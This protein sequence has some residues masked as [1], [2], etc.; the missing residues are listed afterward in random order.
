MTYFAKIIKLDKFEYT[1]WAFQAWSSTKEQ[2][3][4]NYWVHRIV[5]ELSFLKEV[6]KFNQGKYDDLIEET[7]KKLHVQ[8]IENGAISKQ[9]CLNAEESLLVAKEDISKYEISFASHAHIDINW[10]WG[11][12][13][14][15]QITI[16]T[17]RTMLDIMKENENFIY[18]QSQ[19]VLYKIIEDYHPAMLEEIKARVAEKRWEITAS[20]WVEGDKNLANGESQARQ[21]LYTKNY[22]NEIFNVLPEDLIIDFEPDT[23]GHVE[24]I[25]EILDD[26]LVKFY[27]H[28]RG[29]NVTTAYRW[30][31]PSNKE[32]IV[33]RDPKVYTMAINGHIAKNVVE[34]ADKNRLFNILAVYG[35]SNHG[36][37]P[38]RK[39]I[40]MIEDMKH[41]PI[42]PKVKFSSY[43]EY[44][45]YL[46]EN[47][48]VLSVEKRE[49]NAVFNGCYT[50]QSRIKLANRFGENVLYDAET[51]NVI[52]TIN[53]G[54]P[55]SSKKYKDAWLNILTNQ[56]HDILP[57]SGIT[58]T[59][60]YAL[61]KFQE[62]M[63]LALTNK[64]LSLE[65]LSKDIDTSMYQNDLEDYYDTSYGAGVG[66][67]SETFKVSK[68]SRGRGTTRVYHV[69][70][71]LPYERTEQIQIYLWNYEDEISKIK[72]VNSNNEPLKFQK[73]VNPKIVIGGFDGVYETDIYWGHWYKTFTVE[74]NVPAFGYETIVLMQ[75]DELENSFPNYLVIEDDI[76]RVHPEKL[77]ILE[78]DL[79]KVTFDPITLRVSSYYDKELKQELT[80]L[81]GAGFNYILEDGTMGM[82]SWVVGRTISSKEIVSSDAT[83]YQGIVNDI[84]TYEAKV[85]ES[86]F[87]VLITLPKNSK[88]LNYV[89]NVAWNEIGEYHKTI[90]TLNYNF[91][92]KKEIKEYKYDIAFGVTSRVP[93]NIDVSGNS[94]ASAMFEEGAFIITTDSKYGFYGQTDS[95][96]V[97]LI[98][99]STD[100]DRYPEVGN[101]HF[102][103]QVGV[104]NDKANNS[105]IK[106]SKLL[107]HPLD[108]IMGEVHKGNEPLRNSFISVDKQNV[109][110]SSF[111]LSEDKT[112]DLIVRFYES[113]GVDTE[114]VVDINKEIKKANYSNLLEQSLA[115]IDVRNN[116]L[117]AKVKGNSMCSIRLEV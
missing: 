6:S 39:D 28:V 41:W 68:V 13:E 77:Y 38:T 76:P 89:V 46:E 94:F 96:G 53:N 111:K 33:Y 92:L 49:L 21:I 17:F 18:S 4:G 60:E 11:F 110:V 35:V 80:K 62:S 108:V 78:N 85:A 54:F 10:L 106:T 115:E 1:N 74:V 84:L 116:I 51:A 70:N 32:V 99:S 71:T 97:S 23:F 29:N 69:W 15:V 42:Y 55:Y 86:N 14:T 112:N 52:A 104:V 45:E 16:D 36:G 50:S 102:K 22:L 37:G 113:D 59:R 61:G 12:H 90:K 66:F 83:L 43:R 5:S 57:G 107:N 24:S 34:F 25:P 79:V 8:Y 44:Y 82:D 101:H 114:F 117:K 81:N 27:Y 105:L 3:K 103:F 58:Y 64:K 88:L 47:K 91:P 26:G 40:E 109:I 67:N 20:T 73:T 2:S 48:D 63:A 100:P 9:D 65:N 75:D 72:I 30:I 7:S 31:S 93:S 95:I 56:F 19:G 87:S 98:R